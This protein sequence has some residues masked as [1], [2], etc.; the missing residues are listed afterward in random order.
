METTCLAGWTRGSRPD[1]LFRR[2]V[3]D[4][5]AQ[6]RRFLD[7]MQAVCEACGVTPQNVNFGTTYVNVTISAEG[8]ELSPA[9]WEAARRID[10]LLRPSSEAV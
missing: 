2:F 3:F 5:Y 10:A 9:D 7:E 8:P 6:T 4:S 1:H